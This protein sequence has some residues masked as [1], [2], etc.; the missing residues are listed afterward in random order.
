MP[1]GVYNHSVSNSCYNNSANSVTVT[2]ENKVYIFCHYY[3]QHNHSLA[4]KSW[5]TK[6][7]SPCT[8]GLRAFRKPCFFKYGHTKYF[9]CPSKVLNFTC[10]LHCPGTGPWIWQ[11]IL[12]VIVNMHSQVF[13]KLNH[14]IPK[15]KFDILYYLD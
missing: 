5:F 10:G 7:I 12:K 9:R 2:N 11:R 15:I 8:L 4:E 3:E 14:L 13:I 6:N 1:L